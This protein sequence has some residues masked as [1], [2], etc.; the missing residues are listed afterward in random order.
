MTKEQAYEAVQT[1]DAWRD[2]TRGTWTCGRHASGYCCILRL[3]FDKLL[4]L[5]SADT[6]DGARATAAHAVKANHS[7]QVEPRML[8]PA[9]ADAYDN[10]YNNGYRDGARGDED[11]NDNGNPHR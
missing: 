6:P 2:E 9:L 3:P 11:P 1:L 10:G 8:N 7:A 4:G 5:Y